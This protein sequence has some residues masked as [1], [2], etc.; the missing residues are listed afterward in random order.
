MARK[1]H[2]RSPAPTAVPNSR[3]DLFRRTWLSASGLVRVGSR[4]TECNIDCCRRP[5][6]L[7]RIRLDQQNNQGDAD[8]SSVPTA[9]D[10]ATAATAAASEE[11]PVIVDAVTNTADDEDLSAAP[12]PVIFQNREKTTIFGASF[13]ANSVGVSCSSSVSLRIQLVEEPSSTSQHIFNI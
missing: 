1:R 10:D 11:S 2:F 5:L 13:L 4:T 8:E 7:R 6:P 3:H 9:S 12:R